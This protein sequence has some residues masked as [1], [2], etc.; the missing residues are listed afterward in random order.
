MPRILR[1]TRLAHVWHVPAVIV[2]S[3]RRAGPVVIALVLTLSAAQLYVQYRA[4]IDESA[5]ISPLTFI[6]KVLGPRHDAVL[7]HTVGDPW[8]F[9]LLS[10]WGAELF[11]DAARTVGFSQP[12]AVGFLAFRF[13]QN[14]AIFALSFALFRRLGASRPASILGLGLLA[15]AM[16]ESL[17]HVQ[18]SFN[19]YTDIALYLVAALLIL[20]RRWVW[21]V[22]LS[23][24]AALNRETGGLIPV[25]LIAVGIAYGLKTPDGRRAAK[26]GVL[27]VALFA[28]TYGAI[29]L[30]VGP[31]YYILG[32]G[33]HPGF[34]LLRY[35][36]GRGITY[37]FIFET[38]NIV[39]LLAIFSW[40]RWPLE[41]KAFGLTIVPF[42]VV[43]HLF[44]SVIAE[45]RLLL[46]PFAVVLLPGALL[47]LAEPAPV[48]GFAQ[49]GSRS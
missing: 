13:L 42:W 40:R 41:L 12:A 31:G 43:I 10:D 29:R 25:M 3:A 9:R 22:P 44:T 26:L 47:A 39:P 16:S 11:R 1:A 17:L 48:R 38:V 6:E 23:I 15:W 45:T 49:D 7:D 21:I 28:A 8:R 33:N 18:M 36:L 34:E 5:G 35:N 24:V 37:D 19:T 20:D 4:Q 46:V 30:A 27:G 2:R 32:N 14:V